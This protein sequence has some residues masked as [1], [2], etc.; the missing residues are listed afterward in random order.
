MSSED[1]PEETCDYCTITLEE[2]LHIEHDEHGTYCSHRCRSY[3]QNRR[4]AEERA[5]SR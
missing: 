2:Q 1:K 3:A 4:R 5:F